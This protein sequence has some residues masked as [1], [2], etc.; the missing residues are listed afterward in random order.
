MTIFC[1]FLINFQWRSFLTVNNT[2][3]TI[4]PPPLSFFESS[5]EFVFI[6]F[7]G[8]IATTIKSHHISY[9]SD[10]V[11]IFLNDWTAPEC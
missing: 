5:P 9:D 6:L 2:S 8:H 4:S 1:I 3:E 7:C 11:A 10:E